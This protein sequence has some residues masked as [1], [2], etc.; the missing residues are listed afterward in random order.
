VS[1]FAPISLGLR[2]R[3]L[4][5]VVASLLPVYCF[6]I[7]T[8]YTN[9]R[10]SLRRT[11]NELSL[12][13]WQTALASDR[14]IEGVRQLLNA[15]TSGPSLKGFGLTP[16]CLQ[17]LGNIQS[18]YPYYTNLGLAD[19]A[20][21]VQC[22]A[23]ESNAP[24]NFSDQTFFRDAVAKKSFVVGEFQVDQRTKLP[25]LNF[26]MPV[27]DNQGVMKGVAIAGLDLVDKGFGL[28][29]PLPPFT[30]VTVTDRKGTIVGTD[31]ARQNEIG[32]Q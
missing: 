22:Q 8:S 6:S 18:N 3:I 10:D 17:F 14:R 2:S 9:Q 23:F 26:G 15:I 30:Q 11:T 13:A 27:Y 4:W 29:F 24:R 31:I 5:L 20:G 32:S 21:N 12:V 16:L 28:G 1:K 19:Q 25:S 7:Y